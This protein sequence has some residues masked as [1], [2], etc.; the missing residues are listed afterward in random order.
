MPRRRWLAGGAASRRSPQ[1]TAFAPCRPRCEHHRA[2]AP[3]WA[4]LTRNARSACLK[5][6]TGAR[7][8]NESDRGWG[9]EQAA[10]R[11]RRW[12]S[13]ED[14]TGVTDLRAAPSCRIPVECWARNAPS[15][16]A[17]RVSAFAD[18]RQRRRSRISP[19]G[20]AR[21]THRCAPTPRAGTHSPVVDPA[22]SS[23]PRRT[24]RRRGHA[25]PRCR[26]AKAHRARRAE[27]PPAP[28]GTPR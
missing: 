10:D 6:A 20:S 2:T 16:H 27:A 28:R 23:A 14:P 15:S 13:R 5:C 11:R 22:P 7:E 9:S 8:G 25:S 17:R 1:E 12:G 18:R 3:P 19:P 21:R 26:P 24:A 4:V